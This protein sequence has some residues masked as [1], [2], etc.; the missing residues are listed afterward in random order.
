[1]SA[2]HETP[3]GRADIEHLAE[4]ARSGDRRAFEELHRLTEPLVRRVVLARTT[5]RDEVADL[6]QETF[7]RAWTH[8]AALRDPRRVAPWLCQIAR[9]VVTDHGRAAQSRPRLVLLDGEMDGATSPC[10]SVTVEQREALERLWRAV[11][12]LP[13]REAQVITLAVR[14]D[15][16]SEPIA[17]SLGIASGHAKVVLHRA[18]QR[19]RDAVA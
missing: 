8:I 1:M 6:V 4:H 9:H 15:S 5:A 10:P 13:A 3:P 2:T 14:H 7:L 11:S 19:L 12:S 17:A 16:A 18:R